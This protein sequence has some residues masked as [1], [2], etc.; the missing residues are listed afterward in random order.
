MNRNNGARPRRNGGLGLSRIDGVRYRVNVYQ[1]GM[2]AYSRDRLDG[3]DERVSDRDDLIAGSDAKRQQAQ[4]KSG[5]ARV[6]RDTVLRPEITRESVLEPVHLRP[7]S[8]PSAL[9]HT[10]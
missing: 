9:Q 7:E 8:K 4:V 3:R 5:R 6:Q 2:R 1:D 10:I